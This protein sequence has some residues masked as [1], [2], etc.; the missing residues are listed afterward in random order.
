MINTDKSSIFFSQNTSQATQDEVLHLLSPMQ[1][2]RHTK[3]LSL[4]S[5]IGKSKTQIFAE[6]KERVGKKLLGWK[7]KIIS[8]GG[9]EILIKAVAKA[10]P[11]YFM[12]QLPKGLCEELES[13]TRKFWWSQKQQEIKIAW[14]G[15]KKL[16]QPK[17][18]G[19]MGFRSSLA[20]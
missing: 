6:I 19:G 8:I 12:S 1:D 17:L 4:P 2:T 13:M 3:Y 20:S 18:K 16:C 9:K 15:W 7:E 11:T 14:I 10:I 5:L